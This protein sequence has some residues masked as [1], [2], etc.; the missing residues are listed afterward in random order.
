MRCSSFNAPISTGVKRAV[1]T[2]GLK[3][4][5]DNREGMLEEIGLQQ[6]SEGQRGRRNKGLCYYFFGFIFY[7]VFCK[8]SRA[9]LACVGYEQTRFSWRSTKRW[10]CNNS[11]SPCGGGPAFLDCLQECKSGGGGWRRWIRD[12]PKM[13]ELPLS[14]QGPRTVQYRGRLVLVG[15]L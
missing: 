10:M 11:G 2:R 14:S 3:P 8:I 7:L 6:E 4:C 15:A 5:G 1:S 9:A 12:K 13:G